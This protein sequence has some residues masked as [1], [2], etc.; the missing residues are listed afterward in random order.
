MNNKIIH[1]PREILSAIILNC[2]W[3]EPHQ[4]G[5]IL[6]KLENKFSV[7]ENSLD[8]F[9]KNTCLALGE[10][11][12]AGLIEKKASFYILAPEIRGRLKPVIESSKVSG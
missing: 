1:Q 10:G 12:K 2:L 9:I 5:E 4:L 8:K 7:N 6:E 11:I 3:E